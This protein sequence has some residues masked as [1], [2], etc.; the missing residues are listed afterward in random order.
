[1]AETC[2]FGMETLRMGHHSGA[3]GPSFY[4]LSEPI[5]YD[6]GLC[7]WY[8]VML[9]ASESLESGFMAYPGTRERQIVSMEPMNDRSFANA[10]DALRDLGY[11]PVFSL[12]AA[13]EP[14][15]PAP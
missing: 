6:R 5:E 3:P 12:P 13:F 9:P 7:T 1:M 8:A 11:E 4:Q 15:R 2:K 14:L 10:D